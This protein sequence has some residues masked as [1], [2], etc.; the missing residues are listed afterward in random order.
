MFSLPYIVTR[1]FPNHS[2]EDQQR[3]VDECE[4]G[5]KNF[6][7]ETWKDIKREDLQERQVQLDLVRT[8]Y[9]SQNSYYGD[10]E[11]MLRS[12]ENWSAGYIAFDFKDPDVNRFYQQWYCFTGFMHFSYLERKR[13]LFLLGSR[14]IVMAA[15]WDIPLYINIQQ[16]FERYAYVDLLEEDAEMFA[17]ILETNTDVEIGEEGKSKYTIAQWI[18]MMMT[19]KIDDPDTLVDYF[20]QTD[21][22][23]QRLDENN[24]K[25]LYKILT[26]YY[27]IKSGAIWRELKDGSDVVGIEHKTTEDKKTAEEYYLQLLEEANEEQLTIWLQ[28]WK[29]VGLWI[30]NEGKG[31]DFLNKLFYV[32][33][34]KVDL[35]NEQQV[36]PLLE[37]VHAIQGEQT[38]LKLGGD[39]AYFDEKTGTFHWNKDVVDALKEYAAN[40]ALFAQLAEKEETAAEPMANPTPGAQNILPR[41]DRGSNPGV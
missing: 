39:L 5:A 10:I 18:D 20:M 35:S 8:L 41:T 1:L 21:M 22:R 6:Y 2:I 16:Y 9:D 13:Q 37:F 27:A 29:E 4:F 26:V 34:Q 12:L 28:D 17:V 38:G 3:F 33:T 7:W 15:N 36:I 24:K 32:L 14:F 30:L 11:E 25:I 40:P 19:V 31:E 23:V